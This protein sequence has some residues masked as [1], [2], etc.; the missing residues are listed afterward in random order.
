MISLFSDIP[1]AIENTIVIAK[2]CSF[3]AKT[4]KPILPKYPGLKDISENDYLYKI[5]EEGLKKDL[6][7]K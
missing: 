6:S 5:S 7:F 4:H 1:E 3:F 2:R